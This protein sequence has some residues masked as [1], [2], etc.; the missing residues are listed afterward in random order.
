[1]PLS[2]I[3]KGAIG[4][5]AFLITA[6]VTGKGQLEVYVPSADNEG[7]DAEIRRHLKPENSIGVQI[8]VALAAVKSDRGD[9]LFI[10]FH[11]PLHS[12]QNDPSLWYFFAVFDQA[13]LR[14]RD[15]VFLVR[16]DE[17]HRLARQRKLWKQKAVFEIEASLEP[18]AHDRW[19]PYRAALHD[20]GRRLLEIVDSSQL[21]PGTQAK[22]LPSEAVLV[23]RP[24]T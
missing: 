17:F 5:F 23:G 21:A 7:R 2:P 12:I 9:V 18:G 4:Q 14:F 20:L 6:L 13:Q 19:T 24:R 16:A 15:P 22:P 11:L 10:S 1:M 8:K 3:Q